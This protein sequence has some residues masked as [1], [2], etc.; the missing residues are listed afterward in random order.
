[1]NDL[2]QQFGLEFVL[3]DLATRAVYDAMSKEPEKAVDND[4]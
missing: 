1:M 4:D 3:T 2:I